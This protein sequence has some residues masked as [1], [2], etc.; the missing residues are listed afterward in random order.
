[1]L[2]KANIRDPGDPITSYMVLYIDPRILKY[3]Q[4]R[5][6]IARCPYKFPV[7]Q[8]NSGKFRKIKNNDFKNRRQ[9]LYGDHHKKIT[10]NICLKTNENVRGRFF[11]LFVFFVFVF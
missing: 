11:F 10:V 3:H 8:Y 4:F 5:C 6:T 9:K 1:M 7:S 2:T